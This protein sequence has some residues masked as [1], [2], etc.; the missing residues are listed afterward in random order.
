[1]TQPTTDD[2]RAAIASLG[3]IA[4][5]RRVATVERRKSPRARMART[6]QIAWL[7]DEPVKC[8]VRNLSEKGACLE[9]RGEVPRNTFDLIFD[10]D[11]SRRYCWVAWRE[12][13]RMGVKFR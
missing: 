7:G 5:E 4:D 13:P 2:L 9:V 12:P 6:A 8:V 10:L 1:M 11:Q 3:S